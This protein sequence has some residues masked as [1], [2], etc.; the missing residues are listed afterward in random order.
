MGMSDDPS[1]EDIQSLVEQI[2][3]NTPWDVQ[4]W[5][6]T[7]GRWDAATITV[8]AEWDPLAAL[9]PEENSDLAMAAKQFIRE[10]EHEEGAPVDDVIESLT[11]E[12]DVSDAVAQEAIEALKQR[13]EVYEPRTDF[14]R[15]T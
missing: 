1:P 6:H 4:D 2:D 5:T 12:F 3:D 9:S 8:E 13:G 10:D 15:S 7:T 14:L 11:T